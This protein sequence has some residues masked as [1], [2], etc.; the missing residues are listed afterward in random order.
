LRTF[1]ES[2]TGT[3][4]S[5]VRFPATE[6]DP[7]T[8]TVGAGA[9]T[10][11]V[12]FEP[13]SPALST[14]VTLTRYVP[15]AENVRNGTGPFNFSWDFGDG[16]HGWGPGPSHPF[17]SSSATVSVR[18]VVVDSGGGTASSS[19]TVRLVP[20]LAIAGLSEA[21]GTPSVGTPVR[22]TVD[23]TGGAGTK[24]FSWT[25]G[26]GSVSNTA[27]NASHAYGSAGTY[28]AHVFVSDGVGGSAEQQ[29]TITVADSPLLG[30]E[31]A[32]SNPWA[33]LGVALLVAGVVAIYL[34]THPRRPRPTEPAGESEP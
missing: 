17:N 13:R 16:T 18:V 9:T 31:R 30:L 21:P 22:F 7:P 32:L 24:A 19:A 11:V 5:A 15:A 1:P 25:F 14:I 29:I 26:D 6:Y 2:D 12:E 3:D 8:E 27:E 33:I 20:A 23:L 28:T 4:R 10:T 34:R